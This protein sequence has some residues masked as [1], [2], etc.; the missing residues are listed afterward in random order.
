MRIFGIEI[1]CYYNKYNLKKQ[2]PCDY[3]LLRSILK[4][5]ETTVNKSSCFRCERR[6]S[7]AHKKLYLVE[8]CKKGN[9]YR[10]NVV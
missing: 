5:L 1:Y 10:Y 9:K 7:T 3:Y 6:Y 2:L 4:I 8:N